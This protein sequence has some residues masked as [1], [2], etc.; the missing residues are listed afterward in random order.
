MPKEHDPLPKSPAIAQGWLGYA[1]PAALLAAASIPVLF[2]MRRPAGLFVW[3]AGAAFAVLILW[4]VISTLWP[5]R[6]DRTCPECGREELE[7][8]RPDST[9]GVRCAACDW[10]DET[11]SSWLLA[12]E[13]GPLEHTVLQ[14]RRRSAP[15]AGDRG[16]SPSTRLKEG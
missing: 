4:V 16:Q 2:V 7:R 15:P 3:V 14:Q 5:A 8:L 6:A 9:H 12:E 1:M 10:Q 13:E 11:L